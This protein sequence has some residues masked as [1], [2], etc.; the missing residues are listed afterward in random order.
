MFY[1]GLTPL[2]LA[3]S[4]DGKCEG[5]SAR[6]GFR[7]RKLPSNATDNPVYEP[8]SEAVGVVQRCFT[9]REYF[10]FLIG[11]SGSVVFDVHVD[12]VLGPTSDA[13]FN[14]RFS[15]VVMLDSVFGGL[16]DGGYEPR[17]I[18]S[19]SIVVRI[20]QVELGDRKSVV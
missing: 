17:N 15:A 12:P 1:D 18:D 3:V 19:A 16:F 2:W 6:V 7:G 9:L 4:R 20:R 5:A 13:Y 10:Q 14:S 11:N 8:Q